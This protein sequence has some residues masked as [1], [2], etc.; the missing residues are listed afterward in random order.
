[1]PR[2]MRTALTL[3]PVATST[4]GDFVLAVVLVASS[5]VTV[6]PPSGWTVHQDISDNVAGDY[7]VVYFQHVAAAGD[8][9]SFLFSL[10]ATANVTAAEVAYRNVDA[11][12]PID[13]ATNAKFQA[14]QFVAPSITTTHANDFLVTMFVQAMSSTLNWVPPT[15]M[16][17]AVTQGDIGIFDVEQPP[18][19]PTGTKTASF[20][21]GSVPG[22]GAVDY[23]ALTP[24]P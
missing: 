14:A 21:I 19:G 4:A 13:V 15:D 9:S 10:S 12:T 16:Q 3:P 7:R 23:V 8:P 5:S 6:T 24:K 20:G 2:A 22:V 1:M 18:T 17:V 11:T